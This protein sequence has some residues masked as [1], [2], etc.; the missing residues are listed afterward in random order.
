MKTVFVNADNGPECCF[1]YSDLKD[2]HTYYTPPCG[3]FF[4]EECVAQPRLE[5]CTQ[6][7][8]PFEV[9]EPVLVRLS[10]LEDNM[11]EDSSVSSSTSSIQVRVRS[12]REIKI[13]ELLQYLSQK[14]EEVH[15]AIEEALVD[16][17][18][19][20][21]ATAI[22]LR[23]VHQSFID[24]LNEVEEREERHYSMLNSPNTDHV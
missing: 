16:D 3:H 19:I 20:L 2:A 18:G 14:W 1:C 8:V 21:E 22:G 5:T 13:R 12:A 15:D 11:E 4:C 10:Y 17:N 24:E 23:S 9:A 6:C 7:T